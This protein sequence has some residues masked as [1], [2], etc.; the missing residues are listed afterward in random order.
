[1]NR[2]PLSLLFERSTNAHGVL[3]LSAQ[4]FPS[5]GTPGPNRRG[6][7]CPLRPAT[8][9][10]A[11]GHGQAHTAAAASLESRRRRIRARQRRGCEEEGARAAL[12]LGDGQF[13]PARSNPPANEPRTA[14]IE[15]ALVAQGLLTPSNSRRF[16]AWA[17]RW[18]SCARNWRNAAASRRC[19]RGRGRGA[20]ARP[21]GA[22]ESGG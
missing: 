13:R 3:R 6:G 14:L 2:P 11:P 15:R 22:K 20:A 4:S 21:Q 18:P 9:A 5:G 8:S 16:T 12:D 19:D 7:R 1:M 10:P 17:S